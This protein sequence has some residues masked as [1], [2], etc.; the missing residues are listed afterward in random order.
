MPPL[1]YSS[2]GLSTCLS[3][4]VE[5]RMLLLDS[6]NNKPCISPF[7]W[8]LYIVCLCQNG[9]FHAESEN[10]NGGKEWNYMI[11]YSFH[12]WKEG[13]EN[14]FNTQHILSFPCSRNF[15]HLKRPCHYSDFYVENH[16][17]Q[18]NL[19]IYSHVSIFFNQDFGLIHNGAD[20]K[21][22]PSMFLNKSTSFRSHVRGRLHSI[23]FVLSCVLFSFLI[24]QA[25]SK[26]LFFYCKFPEVGSS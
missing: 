8:W 9:A 20:Q 12:Q 17:R 19:Y 14:M 4:S 5:D 21:A 23:T 18:Y 7:H 10:S 24:T 16:T 22:I 1:G 13:Q 11:A 3:Y 15:R 25:T 2:E 26:T 6:S